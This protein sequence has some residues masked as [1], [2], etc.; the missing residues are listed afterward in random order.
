MITLDV[1]CVALPRFLDTLALTALIM[2]IMQ[3]RNVVRWAR[4]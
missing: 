2:Q 4:I 3:L 1:L